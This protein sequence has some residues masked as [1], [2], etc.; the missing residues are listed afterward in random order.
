MACKKLNKLLASGGSM[1][2]ARCVRESASAVV[3]LCGLLV[4]DGMLNVG[5]VCCCCC[6]KKLARELAVGEGVGT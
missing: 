6:A 3:L 4:V 5:V 1:F 2:C